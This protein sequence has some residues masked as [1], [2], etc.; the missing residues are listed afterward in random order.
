MSSLTQHLRSGKQ[1]LQQL[2]PVSVLTPRVTRVLGGNPGPFTLTGTNTYLV[3]TGSKRI[4]FDTGDGLPVFVEHLRAAFDRT[5]CTGLECIVVSHWHHDHLGGV[6]S[7][8]EFLGNEVPVFKFIPASLEE[9]FGGEGARAPY[10]MWPKEKFTH[11]EDGAVLKVEGA[12]LRFHFTPGHANDHMVAMLEEEGAMLSADNVLGTGTGVFRDLT[13]YLDSLQKMHDLKPS[14]LYPGHGP[15]VEDAVARISAYVEH[16][17][18]R[19]RQ[20]EAAFSP[21]AA[22]EEESDPTSTTAS[23]SASVSASEVL[24]LTEITRRVYPADLDPK[25]FRPAMANTANVLRHLA[26]VGV[27]AQLGDEEWKLI[28]APAQL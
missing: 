14:R 21:P 12:T 13:Q 7:V 27:V 10:D 1:V 16:R 8:Q 2:E 17:T 20:V 22:E 6:A 4:L 5:G 9:T 11:L 19:V 28:K 15:V 25:L 3:G 24:S 26:T 23:T 18:A